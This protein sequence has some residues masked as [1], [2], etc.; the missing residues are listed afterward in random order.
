[1]NKLAIR[2]PNASRFLPSPGYRLIEPREV[3][4]ENYEVVGG[5]SGKTVWIPGD[6]SASGELCSGGYG[7]LQVPILAHGPEMVECGCGRHLFEVG[8]DPYSAHREWHEANVYEGYEFSSTGLLRVRGVGASKA[9]AQ[10]GFQLQSAD[11][12]GL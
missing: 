3:I 2:D 5:G 9:R 6:G 10:V 1:M 8:A 7:R 11:G 4:P 12:D